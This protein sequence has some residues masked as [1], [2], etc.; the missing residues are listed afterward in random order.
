MRNRPS[1]LIMGLAVVG[2]LVVVSVSRRAYS[3]T[4]TFAGATNGVDLIT[5]PLGYTGTGGTLTISVGIDPTSANASSM[6]ISVQNIINTIN[7]LVA[8]TGNVVP[9][10]NNNVPPNFFDFEST[11]LHELLHSQG[12]SHPNLASESGLTGVGTKL[13]E[14]DKRC[15]RRVRSESRPRWRHR[16]Q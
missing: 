4:Y 15:E 11:A 6:V 13:H 14:V 2:L 16:I 9:G 8:T 5:H 7:N 3:G 12:L 1:R 10:G